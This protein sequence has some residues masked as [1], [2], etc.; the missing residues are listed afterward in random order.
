MRSTCW[1]T[2]IS[3]HT[4]SVG[5]DPVLGVKMNERL[6][7][8][9]LEA[10]GITMFVPRRVLPAAK[11]SERAVVPQ[12]M[13]AQAESAEKASATDLHLQDQVPSPREAPRP[14]QTAVSDIMETFARPA[15]REEAT[16]TPLVTAPAAEVEPQV[17]FALSIWRPSPALMILDS[18]HAGGALPTQALLAN[19]LR[20]KDLSLPPNKP[21]ILLW[22]PGGMTS[23]LGWS[24]AREMVQAFLQARLEQQPAQYLWL[25]GESAC[26]AVLGDRSYQDSLGMAV[27]VDAFASLAVVLPSLA[28]M[29]QQP[30]L[31]AR[32]WAA[33]RAHHVG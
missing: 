28:D 20:A 11:M 32:T 12:V 17:Q 5:F 18:R 9:Y 1:N 26:N 29:L 16:S 31:K 8:E 27:N 2:V 19:I 22:P 23:A 15:R 7:M 14:V 24:A 30:T 13:S 10:M 3:G 33:I 6:R 4:P 25:M 21:D